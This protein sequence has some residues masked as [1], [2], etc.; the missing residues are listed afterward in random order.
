M[1][2]AKFHKNI[3]YPIFPYQDEHTKSKIHCGHLTTNNARYGLFYVEKITLKNPDIST[4]TLMAMAIPRCKIYRLNTFTDFFV[5]RFKFE[6][7]HIP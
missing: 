5:A 6:V 4:F 1:I 7:S 2:Y 3:Y